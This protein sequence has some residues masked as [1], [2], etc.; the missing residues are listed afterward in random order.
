[1]GA[2]AIIVAAG[3][4]ERLGHGMPKALVRV[5]GRPLVTWSALAIAAARGVDHLV[6]VAPPGDEK[7]VAAAIGDCVPVHAI[8]PGG[9]SRQRSVAAGIA[10]LPDDVDAI[11]VH[12]AARPLVTSAMVDAVLD[13]IG[14]HEGAIAAAPVADTLK[15]EAGDG[16]VGETV[17]RGGLWGAQT[18]Q[19]FRADVIRRVFDDADDAELDAATDCAGMAERRGIAVRLVDTG[20]PNVKVTVPA[21]LTLVEAL[22]GGARIA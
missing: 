5:A 12:D 3:S 19:A 10:A 7:G 2:G 18:P 1:M 6:V 15:R 11:L 16:L 4:G 20:A 17:D 8:V 9:S 13:A 22:L 14:G 21:D